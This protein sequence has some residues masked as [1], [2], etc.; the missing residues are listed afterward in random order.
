MYFYKCSGKHIFCHNTQ[1]NLARYIK[2]FELTLCKSTLTMR[3]TATRVQQRSWSQCAVS[4]PTLTNGVTTQGGA[5]A[6]GGTTQSGTT[7]SGTSQGGTL[8]RDRRNCNNA[9]KTRRPTD[10]FATFGPT[11]IS[12]CNLEV[13][14]RR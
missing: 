2:K 6:N 11:R 12:R 10:V 13:F 1:L 9:R 14:G 7:Q 3:A 5:L 8:I 4:F